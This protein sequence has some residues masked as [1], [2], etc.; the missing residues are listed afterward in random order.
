MEQDWLTHATQPVAN[1]SNDLLTTHIIAGHSVFIV[2]TCKHP[3][4]DYIKPLRQ[5]I[6]SRTKPSK[7][8]ILVATRKRLLELRESF[9][10]QFNKDCDLLIVTTGQLSLLNL[11]QLLP[12][13]HLDCLVLDEL[14]NLQA[15]GGSS[16]QACKSE[17][18]KFCNST[19][20]VVTTRLWIEEEFKDLLQH[21]KQPLMLFKD[22]LEAAAYGGVLLEVALAENVEQQL[23][24]LLAYLK[25]NPPESQCTLIFAARNEDLMLIQQQLPNACLLHRGRK[26]KAR[27]EQWQRQVN[28]RHRNCP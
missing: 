13:A 18:L 27:I 14:Q 16:F 28:N 9:Q 8:I 21:A 6:N 2:D 17:I 15:Y 5:H 1:R 25:Q 22:P 10:N 23:Q 3:L 11:E 4:E 7:C 12:E 20:M 26:D 19:Q 24:Q